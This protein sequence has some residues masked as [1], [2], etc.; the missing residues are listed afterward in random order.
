MNINVEL[1]GALMVK[2]PSS[3]VNVLTSVPLTCTVTPD[4]A[5]SP[6]ETLPLTEVAEAAAVVAGGLAVCANRTEEKALTRSKKRV[7]DFF[8]WTR[9][10]PSAKENSFLLSKQIFMASLFMIKGVKTKT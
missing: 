4:S 3:L 9:S 7:R 6:A 5:V 2:R 10:G 8:R 1:K